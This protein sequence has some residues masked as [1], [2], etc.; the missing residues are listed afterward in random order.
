MMYRIVG[1]VFFVV[2]ALQISGWITL[3]AVVIAFISLLAGV[4]LAFKL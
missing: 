4:A 1:A 2:F 3:P